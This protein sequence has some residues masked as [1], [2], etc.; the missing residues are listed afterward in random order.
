MKKFVMAL[1]LPKESK[2]TD[3]KNTGSKNINSENINKIMIEA[4]ADKN[5]EAKDVVII[6]LNNVS[7]DAIDKFINIGGIDCF[8]FSP[9][10]LLEDSSKDILS[11]V[12]KAD[13]DLGKNTHFLN[14]YDSK[15][16]E[17]VEKSVALGDTLLKD[18]Y[19]TSISHM[20]ICQDQ[21]ILKQNLKGIKNQ[22]LKTREMLMEKEADI[23]DF[24][25]RIVNEIEKDKDEYT[26]KHI[27]SVCMIAE[28]IANKMNMSAKDIE[29][30]KIGALLH[31]IGKKDIT[32]AV[33]KKAQGLT[34]EEFA[35]MK[36]HVSFGEIELNQYD[37]G[38]YERAK[39]ISAEHHEKYDGTG[40]PRGIKGEELDILSRIANVADSVQAM[41]GRAY[42][43]PKTKEE[44]INE[45][46]RCKGTQF[47]PEIADIMAD[48]LDKE[49]E[50]IGVSYDENG[51]VVYEVK[52]IDDIIGNVNNDENKEIR[53][54]KESQENAF[55]EMLPDEKEN[56]FGEILHDGTKNPIDADIRR[57]E[58]GDELNINKDSKSIDENKNIG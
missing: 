42:K 16:E 54:K 29:T 33:L 31:D 38:E 30:L 2:N 21:R 8:A 15:D 12:L 50:S 5:G 22:S 13:K 53:D 10:T 58:S 18:E 48:I 36:S 41:F 51:K 20:D 49:P 26:G 47:D 7:S 3:F 43:E 11:K 56:T 46:N 39:L 19:H 32:D 28:K 24:T 25:K 37:L 40:Y 44:L 1:C 34:D 6:D 57:L 23:L 14:V 45:L 35:E 27:K 9:D 55:E 52:D 4:L 17:N